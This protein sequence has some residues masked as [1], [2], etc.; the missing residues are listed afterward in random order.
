MKRTAVWKL[1]TEEELEALRLAATLMLLAMTDKPKT[2]ADRV[3]L[4]GAINKIGRPLA[5]KP[6]KVKGWIAQ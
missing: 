4:Q 6:E 3:A 1:L 2:D 5:A